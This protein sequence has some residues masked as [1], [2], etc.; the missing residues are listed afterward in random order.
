MHGSR[1]LAAGIATAVCG[2]ALL[3]LAGC[4]TLSDP[5]PL[6]TFLI[7]FDAAPDAA[8]PQRKSAEAVYVAPVSVTAP[9]SERS[10]VVRQSELAFQSDPYAEFAANP[11]SMWTDAVRTWLRERGLFERVLSLG[12]SADAGLTLETSLTEAVVDR[13]PGQAPASRVEM[14]FLLVRNR[15]PFDVLLDRTFAR[16]EP[17]KGAGAEGEVA[18]MSRAAQHVLRDFEDALAAMPQ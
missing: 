14:R 4:G 1:A 6:Q 18:A 11:V 15:A 7:Q 16:D 13:R 8:P 5:P 3:P 10:L 12:S 17:V 2:I 9:F